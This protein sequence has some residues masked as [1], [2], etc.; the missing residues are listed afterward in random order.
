MEKRIVLAGGCFW[1]VEAYYQRLNGI[2]K[3]EV[4]Y[5]NGNI[6]NPT[7]EQVCSGEATHAEVVSVVYDNSLI[8]L[9][10]VLEHF[11]RMIDP[12]SLNKQGNDVGIQYRSGI[13]YENDE[14]H[15][16]V[17]TFI[18]NKQKDTNKKIVVEVLKLQNYYLAENYHQDYLIKNPTGY[19]HID[20][21]LIRPEELK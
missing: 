12:Y 3:T 8:S 9:E 10:K 4:G 2:I 16:T 20:L 17:K 7:Y 1:G 21:S 6:E 14:D 15:E 11:F 5:A 18:A 19:C 13:Y